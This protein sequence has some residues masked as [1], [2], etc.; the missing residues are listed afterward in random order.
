MFPRLRAFRDALIHRRR[1]ESEMEAEMRFHMEAFAADLVRAGTPRAEAERQARVEFGP[2]AGVK[3]ECRQSLGLRLVEEVRQ[4]LAYAARGLRRSP[5]FAAAAVASLA[6]AIGANT[7]I[8]SFVN[9]IAIKPYPYRDSSRLVRLFQG[10]RQVSSTPRELLD[11]RERHDVFS[12]LAA[13]AIFTT[14]ATLSGAAFPASEHTTAVAVTA[15]YFDV[16]GTRPSLGRGFLPE[17]NQ[18]GRAAVAI[19]SNRFW[20]ERTGADPRIAGKRL[21]LNDREYQVV[22]VLPPGSFDRELPQLWTPFEFT[23][24]VLAEEEW[25]TVIA[26]LRPGVSAARA[27]SAL[28]PL[29]YRAE[30]FQ[31]TWER[32]PLRRLLL[33]LWGAVGLLLLMGCANVG[34]LLLARAAARRQEVAIRLSIGAGRLRLLRQF[35]TESLLLSLC[36]G[37]LGLLL[38]LAVTG[39]AMRLVPRYLMPPEANLSADWRVLLFTLAISVVSGILFGLAP[40]WQFSSALSRAMTRGPK[41]RLRAALL[42]AETAIAVILAAGAGLVTHSFTRLSAVDPG[43][44]PANLFTWSVRLPRRQYPTAAGIRAYEDTVLERVQQLPGIESAAAAN[45]LPMQGAFDG[46]V[47]T[48][49]SPRVRAGGMYWMVTPDYLT[50]L[51]LRMV[52]GRWFAPSDGPAAPRI[53]VVNETLARNLFGSGDPLGRSVRLPASGGA[54]MAIV[55][56]VRP[57]RLYGLADTGAPGE[58]YFPVS[59]AADREVSGLRRFVVRTRR[60]AGAIFPAIRE[61]AASI[62]KEQPLFDART[63]EETINGVSFET[64]RFRAALFGGFGLLGLV[65]AS[66]GVYGVLRFAVTQRTHEI[67]VRM[68]LGARGRDVVL[69][70]MRESLLLLAAGLALGMAAAVALTRLLSSLLFEIQPRDPATLTA[71]A[72]VVA[73][74]GVAAAWLPARRAASVHPV[75]T[76]RHE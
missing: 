68:A 54:S 49:G 28:S 16:L 36:G 42:V 44:Q 26:R 48:A 75:A 5:G 1:F 52:K 47:E 69:L 20:R 24:A 71:V 66:A 13:R 37:A 57:T 55:G 22:G 40:G 33:L 8:F 35:L 32:A 62:D 12:D 65:L 64:P 10:T 6:L 70:V 4:D 21:R 29:G 19:L 41:N 39:L 45:A 23:P 15:N 18:P 56:V 27:G 74:S 50:T 30:L 73:L 25:L 2:L 61:I 67:G 46:P 60:N 7:V 59:Q 9:G 38:A 53:A 43:F 72:A 17:E 58:I 76:L 63:M 51:R 3:E 11:L 14:D 34:N 31:Y